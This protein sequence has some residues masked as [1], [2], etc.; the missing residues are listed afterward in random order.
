MQALARKILLFA[1]L[2][3][4]QT[5]ATAQSNQPPPK[6]DKEHTGS[7]SGRVT[8]SGKPLVGVAVILVDQSQSTRQTQVARTTTDQEGRY[9]L[10]SIPEGSYSVHPLMLAYVEANQGGEPRSASQ[11]ALEE[12]ESVD[13]IDFSLV[14]GGVITGRVV[15]ADNRPIIGAHVQMIPVDE[16]YGF[17]NFSI[18]LGTDDRGVYRIFGLPA[19]RYQVAI[20]EDENR[21]R[22]GAGHNYY[23]RTY[24]PDAKEKSNA[25]VIEVRPGSEVTGVDITVG[26][27][28]KTYTVTGRVVDAISGKPMANVPVGYGSFSKDEKG[29]Q[30]YSYSDNQRTDSNG[31]FRLTGI[32]KGDYAAFAILDDQ[33]DYYSELTPFE[34]N[35]GDVSGLEIKARRGS[36][37]SGTAIVEGITDADVLGKLAQL[38]IYAH[39]AGGGQIAPRATRLAINPDLSF[40]ATGLPSGKAMIYLQSSDKQKGFS[41][42]RTERDGVDQGETIDIKPGEQVTGVRIVLSHGAG[43]LR[44]TIKVEGG[45]VPEGAQFFY[46]IRS[47]D[48]KQVDDD[49]SNQA[50]SR[51]RFVIEGLLT[52]TYDVSVHMVPAGSGQFPNLVKTA[53]QSVSITSGATTTVN[54][55]INLAEK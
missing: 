52:G 22:H 47:S 7:I 10:T 49:G 55:V 53:R 3:S 40:R 18:M 48:G 46:D 15:D 54:L 21:M 50:D 37:L 26:R 25:T 45:E 51:G 28:A 44:G 13:G 9:Q 43:V 42:V 24:H 34:I 33:Q 35:A 8:L 39:V 12:G 1:L 31:G 32:G 38:Q 4:L 11:I 19:G 6:S 36:T 20:G 17:Y 29:T 41:I 14:P 5:L 30:S 27:I 2:L 23:V 16:T